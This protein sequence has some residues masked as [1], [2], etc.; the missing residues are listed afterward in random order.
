M[1]P[2]RGGASS[3]APLIVLAELGVGLVCVPDFLVRR[4]LEAGSLVALLSKQVGQTETIR[5]VWPSN[6]YAPPKLR[7][8][9]DFLFP[10][11][12]TRGSGGDFSYAREAKA[13]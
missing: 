6:R 5:A 12:L 10:N 11:L 13:C 8:F 9:V 2:S 7:A 4:Q 3:F 1:V